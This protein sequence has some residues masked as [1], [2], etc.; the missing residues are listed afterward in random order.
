MTGQQVQV[1]GLGSR[2]IYDTAEDAIKFY[3][4]K[5]GIVDKERAKEYELIISQ[6]SEGKTTVFDE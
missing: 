1:V 2:A 5:L 3:Q 4:E 6:L